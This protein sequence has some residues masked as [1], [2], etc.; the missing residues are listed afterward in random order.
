MK[1]TELTM[2]E[3]VR[4][5]RKAEQTVL[6]KGTDLDMELLHSGYVLVTVVDTGKQ[7]VVGPGNV[8]HAEVA[9]KQ[10]AKVAGK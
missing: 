8:R 7:I 10:I 3:R 5:P 6:L 9:P 4:D 1:L 2:N